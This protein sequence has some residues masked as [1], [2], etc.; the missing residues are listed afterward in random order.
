MRVMNPRWLAVMC[1]LS[2]LAACARGGM[3][4]SDVPVVPAK[5]NASGAKA[6]CDACVLDATRYLRQLSLDLRGRPPTMEELAEVER[7]GDVTPE[8]LDAML[9]SDDLVARAREWHRALLWPS[10]DNFKVHAT[11]I[12]AT[13]P[14][15]QNKRERR[16][17]SP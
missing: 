15:L 14:N 17:F 4:R 12:V 9:R 2:A 1:L 3:S 10:L 5:A 8:I 13:E 11:P 16:G 7:A 6:T